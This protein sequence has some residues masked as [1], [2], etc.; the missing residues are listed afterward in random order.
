[1]K[2]REIQ[3]RDIM[4]CASM[5]LTHNASRYYDVISISWLELYTL[6]LL[7]FWLPILTFVI[8]GVVQPASINAAIVP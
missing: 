5:L 4:R 6:T 8:A 7:P 2:K 1:M 3:G